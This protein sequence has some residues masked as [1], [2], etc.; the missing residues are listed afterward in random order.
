MEFHQIRIEFPGFGIAERNLVVA[1]LIFRKMDKVQEAHMD[2][3]FQ[4]IVGIAL[5]QLPGIHP[6]EIEQHAVR[7]VREIHDLHFHIDLSAV[8]E[9]YCHIQD[10]QL[11]VAVFSGQ[12]RGQ[13][14]GFLDLFR[15]S[16][17]ERCD[18]SFSY[19]FI[20]H[21]FFET[22]I[23][24]GKHYEIVGCLCHRR[25]SFL[26][27]N[28]VSRRRAFAA[29]SPANAAP[30]RKGSGLSLFYHIS[31]MCKGESVSRGFSVWG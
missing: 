5:F 18:E 1:F 19:F 6:A 4:L 13:Q 11:I 26:C 12:D 10:T 14:C 24:C 9:K 27:C 17:K 20:L 15:L 16:A 25:F 3:F 28:C 8:P 23:H 22:E 30:Y 21:Q 29:P 2:T 7:P 31:L